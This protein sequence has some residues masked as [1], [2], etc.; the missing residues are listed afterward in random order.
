[1]PASSLN[2]NPNHITDQ[3]GWGWYDV[4][5][6]GAGARLTLF[7]D[8]SPDATANPNAKHLGHTTE[9][10]EFAAKK[11]SEDINVDE[12]VAPVD[13]IITNL[14]VSLAANLAQTQDISGVLRYLTQGFGSY[15]TA[16]GY[17]QVTLGII[18]LVY[19]AVALITPTKNDS[20]KFFVYN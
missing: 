11:E 3:Y 1:M 8:G 7:T 15:S 9:G 6:P 19:A 20:T 14:P 2:F 17:E 10:W 12:A 13:R 5:I 4:A 18:P 16:A